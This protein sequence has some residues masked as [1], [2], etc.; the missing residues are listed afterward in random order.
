MSMKAG[1]DWSI[2]W[3]LM[4]PPAQKLEKFAS[5]RMNAVI[6]NNTNNDTLR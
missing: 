5:S 1:N 4:K 6:E 3:S 2:L